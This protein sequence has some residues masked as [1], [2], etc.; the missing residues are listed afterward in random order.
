MRVLAITDGI[1]NIDAVTAAATVDAG[2][3]ATS[4][5]ARDLIPISA[6]VAG[7]RRALA[8]NFEGQMSVHSV[9]GPLRTEVPSTIFT[10]ATNGSKTA[11]IDA[12]EVCGL[13]L[14]PAAQRDPRRT[15]SRGV[16]DR[17]EGA[18]ATGAS[19]SII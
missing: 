7:F 10:T 12:A 16:A 17:L 15:T 9:H 4:V 8:A 3:R 19:R 13:H 11:Y 6:G 5:D 1:G 18:V 14:V 2:C